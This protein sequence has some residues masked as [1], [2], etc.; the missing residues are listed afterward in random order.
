MVKVYHE[1]DVKPDLIKKKTV[2]I[3]GYGSQGHAHAN[4]LKESG[5]NVVVGELLDGDNA[6]KAREAGFEVLDAAGATAKADV[7]AMLLP[8]EF[9]GS[10]YKNSVAPNIK[11]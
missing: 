8:D 1:S 4:N 10:I 3:L 7:V 9:Q 2:A 11:K 6:R 5:V